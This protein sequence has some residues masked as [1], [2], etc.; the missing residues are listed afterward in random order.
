MFSEI[1]KKI[2]TLLRNFK[3]EYGDS[4]GKYLLQSS[5]ISIAIIVLLNIVGGTNVT[6]LGI[7]E[8]ILTIPI[9][10]VIVILIRMA[11]KCVHTILPQ[12]GIIRLLIDII[13]SIVVITAIGYFMPTMDSNIVSTI[14]LIVF[15]LLY[16]AVVIFLISPGQSQIEDK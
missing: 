7:I 3:N 1:I 11:L 14:L 10:S 5:L 16:T 6:L 12:G 4:I 2:K 8:W 9:F 15:D 13:V